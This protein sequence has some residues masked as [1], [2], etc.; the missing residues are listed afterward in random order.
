MAKIETRYKHMARPVATAIGHDLL[1]DNS[2]R[3]NLPHDSWS[4]DNSAHDLSPLT[5][6]PKATRLMT[7]HRMKIC[8]TT[9]RPME[10]SLHD[11]AP[12]GQLIP[13]ATRPWKCRGSTCP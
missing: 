5:V 9:T 11:N 8:P 4:Y 12:H 2:P 13:Q 1:S 3:D 10:N 6:R 7:T